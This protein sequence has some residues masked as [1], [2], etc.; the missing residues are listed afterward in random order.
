MTAPKIHITSGMAWRD[1]DPCEL[2]SYAGETE[3]PFRAEPAPIPKP[4]VSFA[5]W[6]GVGSVVLFYAIGAAILYEVFR[7]ALVQHVLRVMG[8]SP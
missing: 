3:P 4:R 6:R 5:F 2:R 1:R 8:V 7:P